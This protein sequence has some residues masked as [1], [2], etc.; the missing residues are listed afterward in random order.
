MNTKSYLKQEDKKYIH[1]AIEK[2]EEVVFS[3]TGLNHEEKEKFKEILQV[4]LA[5]CNQ[6]NMFGYLS[7]CL[8][9]LLDNANR[10]NVKR[11]YFKKNN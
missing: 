1:S 6:E 8:L 9:E 10:A 7:Y 4:F 5:E 3:C 2:R 11:I